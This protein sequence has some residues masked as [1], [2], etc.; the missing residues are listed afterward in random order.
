MAQAET[1]RTTLYTSPEAAWGEAIGQGALA[2]KMY[3]LRM[4]GESLVHNKRT[5]TSETIREDRQR[6]SITEVGA[7]AEGGINFEMAF[8]SWDLVLESLLATNFQWI[9]ETAYGAGTI[10]A[11]AAGNTFDSS[12]DAVFS[13]L[14]VGAEIWV[15]GFSANAANNGRFIITAIDNGVG[16][17]AITVAPTNPANNVLTNETPG[18][19]VTIRSN[20]F[21]AAA[22]ISVTANNTVTSSSTDFTTDVNLEV[23]QWV[24]FAGFVNSE[25]NS[26]FKITG[27]SANAL[28]LDT[29]ALVTE[30][31]AANVVITGKRAK[32]GTEKKSLLI[33][34]RF[35]DVTEF[36]DFQGMRPGEMTLAIE[37]EAIVN[38]TFNMMGK[39]GITAASTVAGVAVP[40]GLT[41]PLNATVNL[42]TLEEGG[43]TIVTANRAINLSIQ[44]NL[45]M[46]P[47]TGSRSPVDIGYGFVDVSGSAMF[48]FEDATLLDKFIQHTESSFS[49]PLIDED[50]NVIYVTLPRLYFTGGSNPQA[51]GG[52]DD[53]MIP[54]EF[55]AIRDQ[56][57]A[58]TITFDMLQA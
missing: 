2:P 46:K 28:T 4:T 21:T 40:A 58:T 56:A 22:D 41:T 11:N 42:G 32:N 33:E 19:A 48:Y 47:Q 17:T 12:V 36:F 34:K 20:K 54:M 6:D 37:S 49:F 15:S 7:N 13:Q 29:T 10:S 8:F 1:N 50:G 57:L 38:G 44:N 31:A 5:V 35:T 16:T 55:T 23:G 14:V 51:P 24:R 25:N 9:E 39:E 43:S 30:G 53:V 26:Y 52:N 27:I 45:R 3:Q 18:G